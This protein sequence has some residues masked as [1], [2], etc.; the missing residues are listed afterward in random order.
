VGTLTIAGIKAIS[1]PGRYIDGDGLMLRVT[2]SGSKNWILR[3][4]LKA[5]AAM[6][7]WAHSRS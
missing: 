6:W 5:S 7:A 4:L 2:E 1:E 3:V